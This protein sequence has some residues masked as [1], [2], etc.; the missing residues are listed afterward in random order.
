MS[1]HEIKDMNNTMTGDCL[2]KARKIAIAVIHNIYDDVE[3]DEMI[4]DVD[5]HKV[6]KSLQILEIS[7]HISTMVKS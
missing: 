1:M 3:D 5:L 7:Q 4:S 6:K 2:M